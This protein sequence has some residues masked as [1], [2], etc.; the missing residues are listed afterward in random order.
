MSSG[1]VDVEWCEV[2]GMPG[3][4]VPRAARRAGLGADGTVWIPAAALGSET[5][6]FLMLGYDGEPGVRYDGGMYVR[7]EWARREFPGARDIVDTIARKVR[8]FLGV[9]DA[10]TERRT[11]SA[12]AHAMSATVKF[13]KNGDTMAITTD[14][15]TEEEFFA[16]AASA[17]DTMIEEK[18]F[19]HD[20]AFQLEYWLPQM[21]DIVCKIRGYKAP[22]VQEVRML[23]AG[24]IPPDDADLVV[25]LDRKGNRTFGTFKPLDEAEFGQL[26]EAV[27]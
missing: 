1:F 27:K 14:A 5:E 13:Y 17:L 7:E 20:W 9:T 6:I 23:A 12:K 18:L 15:I 4:R 8:E 16:A 26:V 24:H 11:P 25:A 21:V 22:T 10:V 19:G 2:A 3:K